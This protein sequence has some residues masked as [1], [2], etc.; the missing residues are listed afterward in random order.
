MHH[1]LVVSSASGRPPVGSVHFQQNHLAETLGVPIS[2]YFRL[3]SG[4]AL[5]TKSDGAAALQE[6]AGKVSFTRNC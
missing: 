6:G 4:F 5:T 3:P 1:F 2:M